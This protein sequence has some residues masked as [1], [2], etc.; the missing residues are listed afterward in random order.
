TV[1]RAASAARTASGRGRLSWSHPPAA[2][3]VSTVVG[4]PSSQ[5]TA[6]RGQSV[7]RLPMNGPKATGSLPTGSVAVIVP[8]AVSR[9]LTVSGPFATYACSPVRSSPTP[10]GPRPTGTVAVGTS[11]RAS[12]T[13]T[14][15]L[16]AFVT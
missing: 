15:S 8:R 2:V 1:S 3:H 7:A 4:S 12:S 16:A 14:V 10:S 11:V 5:E 9:T 6:G 13:D